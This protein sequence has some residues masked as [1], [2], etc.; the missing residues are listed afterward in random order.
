MKNLTRKIHR[1]YHRVKR[2]IFFIPII[3]KGEDYDYDY[4]IELFKVQ[5]SRMADFFEGPGAYT[6]SSSLN[7][8]RIRTIVKLMDKIYNNEYQEEYISIVESKYGKD[9]LGSKLVKTDNGWKW[10]SNFSSQENAEEIEDFMY[11]EMIHSQE[12]HEKAHRLLWQ[13]IEKDIQN[14]WD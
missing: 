12:K 6:E 11:K 9:I 2:F 10:E 3:W 4:A 14:W 1:L 8:K 13:L 5:L 7:A